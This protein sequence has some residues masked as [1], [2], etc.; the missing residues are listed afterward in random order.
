MSSTIEN[1]TYRDS[2]GVSRQVE[3]CNLYQ[4]KAGRYWLWSESLEHNLAH[5]IKEKEDCLLAAI[6]SLLFTIQLKEECIMSLQRIVHL[7]QRF[8]DEIGEN[9]D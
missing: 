3:G 4:D 2:D 6:S 9:D 5:K 1:L 8:A 7:A